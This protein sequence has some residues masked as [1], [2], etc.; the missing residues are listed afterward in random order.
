MKLSDIR[1]EQSNPFFIMS[2]D[3]C[4]FRLEMYGEDSHNSM[5]ARAN[6][7]TELTG[8]TTEVFVVKSVGVYRKTKGD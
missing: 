5:T 4:D 2:C 6:D 7:H 8:H 3:D 1:R